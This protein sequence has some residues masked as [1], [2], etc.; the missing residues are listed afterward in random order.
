MP[1]QLLPSVRAPFLEIV[2]TVPS[3]KSGGTAPFNQTAI[4][5][6]SYI[7]LN[8]FR[9]VIEQFSEKGEGIILHLAKGIFYL[10]VWGWRNIL[11][12]FLS[13]IQL[14]LCPVAVD[15][16]KYSLNFLICKSSVVNSVPYSSLSILILLILFK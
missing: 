16:E 6:A 15:D 11:H 4:L 7:L 3:F 12:S 9:A 13:Y 14:F 1:L 5:K 10:R 2:I 8:W